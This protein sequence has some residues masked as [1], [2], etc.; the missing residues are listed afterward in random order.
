MLTAAIALMIFGAVLA[1][2][3]F[4][5]RWQYRRADELL[6]E[7]ARHHSYRVLERQ[8]RTAPGDGPMNRSARNKQVVYSVKL[9]DQDGNVRLAQV[10]VGSPETGVLSDRVSVEW[11]R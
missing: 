3:I 1:L 5:L 10:S 8:E 7:W 11:E 6:D 2:G 9:I 4:M